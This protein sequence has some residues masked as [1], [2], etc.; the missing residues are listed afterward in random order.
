MSLL[1]FDVHLRIQ[2]LYEDVVRLNPVP[3]AI[4]EGT[5]TVELSLEPY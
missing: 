4:K 2:A 5:T 3:I 1:T